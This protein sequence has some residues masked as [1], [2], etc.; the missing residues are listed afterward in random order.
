MQAEKKSHNT[1]HSGEK[2]V[3]RELNTRE[4]MLKRLAYVAYVFCLF[5]GFILAVRGV[6]ASREEEILAAV[7]LAIVACVLRSYGIKYLELRRLAESFP[8]GSRQDHLSEEQRRETECLL[9]AF[10]NTED[11]TERQ[12]IRRRLETLV[13]HEPL[14]ME[15]YG[16]ELI[17]VHPTLVHAAW[18]TEEPQP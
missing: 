9:A 4:E 18:G 17:K 5:F 13:A 3:H 2:R 11:W 1:V 10:H 8:M 6:A 12:E 7:L 14:L 15:A 16:S